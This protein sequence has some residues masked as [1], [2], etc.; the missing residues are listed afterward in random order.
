MERRDD[1]CAF[2]HRPGHALDR[3]GADIADR[4]HA[5]AIGLE[6]QATVG[7]KRIGAYESPVIDLDVGMAEP[8]GI[9]VSADEQKQMVQRPA[10]Y[11]AAVTILPGDALQFAVLPLQLYHL[12]I[13]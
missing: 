2:A 13:E 5:G 12:V 9:G 11:R 8:G 10:R 1:L 7:G 4:K 6:G 3:A